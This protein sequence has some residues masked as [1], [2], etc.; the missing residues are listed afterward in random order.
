MSLRERVVLGGE[1]ERE[2][3]PI[4][5]MRRSLRRLMKGSGGGSCPG[6]S[7]KDAWQRESRSLLDNRAISVESQ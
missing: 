5:S 4:I 1:L 3:K 2:P 6:Y 7:F